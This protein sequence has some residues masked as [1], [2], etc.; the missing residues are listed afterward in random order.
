[1]VIVL[2]PGTE[3]ARKQ[4]PKKEISFSFQCVSFNISFLSINHQLYG[5]NN[6]FTIKKSINNGQFPA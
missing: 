1:M 2:K 5:K 3:K 4:V 6:I